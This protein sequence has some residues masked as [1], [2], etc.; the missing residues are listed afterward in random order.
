[1]PFLIIHKKSLNIASFEIKTTKKGMQVQGSDITRGC[2]SKKSTLIKLTT[3]LPVHAAIS[4][5]SSYRNKEGLFVLYAIIWHYYH[6]FFQIQF[7]CIIVIAGIFTAC[8]HQCSVVPP[9][10]KER[11]HVSEP[12]HKV[13][14]LNSLFS[15]DDVFG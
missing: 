10:P 15:L 12:Y 7:C 4:A 9:Q 6:C 14:Q 2:N 8:V 3:L 5:Y 1:M 11:Y 13:G